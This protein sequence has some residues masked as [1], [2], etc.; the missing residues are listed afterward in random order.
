VATQFSN[1]G[2]RGAFVK[3]DRKERFIVQNGIL[4]RARFNG[5]QISLPFAL[6]FADLETNR[7]RLVF[8][9][10]R[11][12]RLVQSQ[13]DNS[14]PIAAL[15]RLQFKHGFAMPEFRADLVIAPKS[16]P[17]QKSGDD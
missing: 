16:V 10:E 3:V 6:G 7:H 1:F 12:Y 9:H 14:W 11:D 8:R 4:A 17:G 15:L 13:E 2:V 5:A